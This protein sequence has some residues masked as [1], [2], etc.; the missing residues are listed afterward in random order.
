MIG[1]VRDLGRLRRAMEGCEVVVHCAALKRIEVGEYDP[2]EMV[3]TNVVGSRNVVEGA[4]D[5]GV[6]RVVLISSDKAVGPV[7]CYG[8]TKLVAEK[9]FRAAGVLSGDRVSACVVRYGNVAGSTGSVIPL[10]RG[11]GGEAKVTDPE[12]TRYWLEVGE[13]VEL[14]VRA[15]GGEEGLIVPRLRAFRLGDLAVAMGV[16]ARVVGLPDGEKLHETLDGASYSNS[17]PRMSVEELRE[18]VARL[19][20]SVTPFVTSVAVKAV[21]SSKVNSGVGKGKRRGKRAVGKKPSRAVYMRAYRAKRVD[22]TKRDR[23]PVAPVSRGIDPP[24][25]GEP[26]AR[27]VPDE[28]GELSPVDNMGEGR[29][30]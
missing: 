14:V 23:A 3:E 16:R 4:I 12:C 19:D 29:W 22:P 26:E 27:S 18:A 6:R 5:V 8:A 7:N 9:L 1:D 15:V 25:G 10:W 20:K 28:V 2:G 21:M 24:V 30:V 11:G 17:A 13:A